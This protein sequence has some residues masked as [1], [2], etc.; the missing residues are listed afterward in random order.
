MICLKRDRKP[1]TLLWKNA[2]NVAS[3]N[4]LKK[5]RELP[6]KLLQ[7]NESKKKQ[8]QFFQLPFQWKGI[9]WTMKRERCWRKSR[10]QSPSQKPKFSHQQRQR[11][12]CQM[13]NGLKS[14]KHTKSFRKLK[15]S[16]TMGKKFKW[17]SHLRNSSSTSFQPLISSHLTSRKIN[18]K[19]KT[20]FARTSAFWKRPLQA[21]ISRRQWSGRKSVLLSPSMKSSQ[22]SVCGSTAFRT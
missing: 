5:K 4:S 14:L 18:P 11:S 16:R 13:K 6:R 17:I 2:K 22:L 10:S 21:S 8:V 7:L 15:N 12:T 1:S 3:R 9:L 19:R 20:S